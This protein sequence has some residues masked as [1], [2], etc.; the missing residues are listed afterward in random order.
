MRNRA[1]AAALLLAFAAQCAHG[2]VAPTHI[3]M[4]R[5]AQQPLLRARQA[6][7]G[8]L[9]MAEATTA[10]AD[11]KFAK[12]L[13]DCKDWG[14]C[15]FITINAAGAVLVSKPAFHEPPEPTYTKTRNPKPETLK[16][17]TLNAGN[18]IADGRGP[19]VFRSAREGSV[20]DTG[21]VRERVSCKKRNENR[22]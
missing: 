12:L 5:P 17:L 10:P 14:L 16:P 2:Y 4:S 6:A 21:Q 7:C 18:R 15:R 3:A 11:G 13:A 20:R 19:Q 1:T 22:V 8:R 9:R